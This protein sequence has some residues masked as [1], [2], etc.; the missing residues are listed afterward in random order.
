MAGPSLI[1]EAIY[2]GTN[3]HSIQ[4]AVRGSNDG[5]QVGETGPRGG[6]EASPPQL[7]SHPPLYAFVDGKSRLYN[8]LVLSDLNP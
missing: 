5:P 7:G 3:V 4:G 1:P 2:G 6:R 8:T